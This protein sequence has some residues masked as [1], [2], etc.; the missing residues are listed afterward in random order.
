M[1]RAYS[2]PP[3]KFGDPSN[4]TSLMEH[5]TAKRYRHFM[6]QGANPIILQAERFINC[7]TN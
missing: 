7:F 6:I 5:I 4:F 2:N 3:F 1:I